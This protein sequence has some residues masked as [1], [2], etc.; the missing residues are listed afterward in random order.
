MSDLIS[1]APINLR[2]WEHKISCSHSKVMDL[3][4]TRV[5][6]VASELGVLKP[7]AKVITLAGTNG[8][9]TTAN[10]LNILLSGINKKVGVYTSPHLLKI[11]ERFRIN[12]FLVA[13]EL[14]AQAFSKVDE[15]SKNLKVSLT[16]FEYCCLASFWLFKQQKCDVWVLEVGLGGRLDAINIIDAD[17]AVITSIDLDH[18]D[19]LG[20]TREQIVVEKMG[21]FRKE[22]VI[23][24]GDPRADN[25]LEL[26]KSRAFDLGAQ[27]YSRGIDYKFSNNKFS[28]NKSESNLKLSDLEVRSAKNTYNFHDLHLATGHIPED[29]IATAVMV[30]ILFCDLSG[31]LY[32][33]ELSD[34]IYNL[35]KDSV[36]NLKV[37]GRMTELSPQQTNLAARVICDG[38]HNAHAAKYLASRLD[39]L[40]CINNINN[41]NDFNKSDIKTHKTL[42]FVFSS[43]ADKDFK[44]VLSE[45]LKFSEVYDVRWYLCTVDHLRAVKYEDLLIIKDYLEGLGQR[46]DYVESYPHNSP[47]PSIYDIL[48]SKI[49]VSGDEGDLT[50][51][52]AADE[53]VIFG[54]FYLLARFFTDFGFCDI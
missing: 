38:A 1:D 48:P 5:R 20:D 28:N 21:I 9:G 25:I 49:S 32:S 45:M 22:Q 33:R 8:K 53:V 43:L 34:Y 16:Y 40:I 29:N 30:F 36:L 27:L 37:S 15:A 41:I 3:G 6:Q 19:I 46:V 47:M 42:H 4:L 54:S 52:Q 17:I 24:Y 44:Q 13:D 12:N 2:S 23:V 51:I 35:V 50:K 14:L 11:N 10:L 7:A 18:T 26:V 39:K 31:N